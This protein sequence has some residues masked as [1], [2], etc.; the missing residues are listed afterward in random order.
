MNLRNNKEAL[1]NNFLGGLLFYD[2]IV[3]IKENWLLCDSNLGKGLGKPAHFEACSTPRKVQFQP[4]E[5]VRKCY[6]KSCELPYFRGLNTKMFKNVV[7]GF[8]RHPG[9][10]AQD[11]HESLKFAFSKKGASQVASTTEFHIA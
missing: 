10:R 11:E 1:R 2:I 3:L 6:K 7:Y 4:A 9:C 8:S 5:M